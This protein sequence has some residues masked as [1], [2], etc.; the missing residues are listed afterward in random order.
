MARQPLTTVTVRRPWHWGIAIISDATIGGQI[1][2]VEAGRPVSANE[3]GLIVLVHHAQDTDDWPE[4]E[5]WADD[6]AEVEWAQASV[7]LT[8]WA[9]VSDWP[10][11]DVV[12]YDGRLE[13][14]SGRL[15]V[16][17]ADEDVVISCPTGQI[18]LRVCGDGAP[19]RPDR[20][21]IDLAQE[22]QPAQAEAAL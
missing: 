7:V 10:D 18:R 3:Y 6:D 11:R 17:D 12:L 21:Q 14:P 13:T 2:E 20:V 19:E 16:G 9:A 22:E 4:G 8:S 1:P 5:E 15:S